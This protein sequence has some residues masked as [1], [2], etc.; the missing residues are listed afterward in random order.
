MQD[1]VESIDMDLSDDDLQQTISENIKVLVDPAK[2]DMDMEKSDLMPPPP[3]PDIPDDIDANNLLDDLDN[4]LNS[5]E[6]CES[7]TDDANYQENPHWIQ[8][9]QQPPLGNNWP[10]PE[11]WSETQ[12]PPGNWSETQPPPGN[13]SESQPPPPQQYQNFGNNFRGRGN[14]KRGGNWVPRGG[15]GRGFPPFRGGRGHRGNGRGGA[16]Q[17]NRGGWGR[18]GFRGNFRGGY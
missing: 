13:W 14:V 7:F 11:N 16:F 8:Q 5:G 6:F 1:N 10:E 9:Q 3:P 4:D 2:D 15:R 18:G 17:N 12:L